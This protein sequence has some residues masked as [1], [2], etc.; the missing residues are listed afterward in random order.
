MQRC[1]K[2]VT[3]LELWAVTKATVAT[4]T[5]AKFHYVLFLALRLLS[6]EGPD[7]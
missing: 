1:L 5:P 6:S 4:V 3:P 2:E 7:E